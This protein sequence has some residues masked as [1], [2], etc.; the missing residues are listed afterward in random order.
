MDDFVNDT[1]FHNKLVENPL[2]LD[3]SQPFVSIKFD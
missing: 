1:V 2:P 3:Q